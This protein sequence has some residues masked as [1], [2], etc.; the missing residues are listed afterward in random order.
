VTKRTIVAALAL[1]G[2]FVAL[3]LL[4]YKIGVVGNLSCSIGSCETVNLSKWAV[5]LGAPVA[6]WGVAFYV[7]MFC[8]ALVSLQD[9]YADSLGMSKLLVLVSGAGFLFSAWLTSLELFVIHAICQWCV[10]S[11]IIVT[12]IF[13]VSVLDLRAGHR[14]TES[15]ENYAN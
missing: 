1:A 14:V 15:T 4:L 5:F 2:I 10:I 11:A 13:V 6:G 9:R 12:L 3:Y 8:L 7:V